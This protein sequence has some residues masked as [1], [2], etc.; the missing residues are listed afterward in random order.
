MCKCFIRG[1][2][3]KIEQRITRN[4]GVQETIAD[5]LR[6]EKELH[7]MT[8]LKL[9]PDKCEFLKTEVIYLGHVISKDG[10]KPDPKK[11]EAVRQFPRPKTSKNIKQFLELAGYLTTDASGIAIGGILSQGEINKDRPIAYASRTL[12]KNE[13]KYDIYEKEALA[14]VYCVKHFRLKMHRTQTCKRMHK[15]TMK[16]K[17]KKKNLRKDIQFRNLKEKR[18]NLLLLT[19]TNNQELHAPARRNFP[20]RRVIVR[21]YDDLWQT[22]VVEMRP[23]SGFNIDVLSKYTWAVY[24]LLKSKGGSE[25]AN[26]IAE[27]VRESRRCPKNLQTD[28]AKE[29]YNVDVQKILKKHD[30]NHYSTLK[31]SVIERFNRTF[32]NDIAIKI[33][34]PAKFKIGDSV[35]VSKY[36]TIF[37]KGYTPNWT[38]EV[39]TIVKVQ[40]TNPVT[41]LYYYKVVKYKKHYQLAL[42]I[43]EGQRQGPTMTLIYHF[44]RNKRFTVVTENLKLETVSIAK[45]D[46][47]NNV[48]WSNIKTALQLVVMDSTIK[49]IICNGL[50]KYPP[51]DFRSTIIGEMHCL[52]TGRHRGVTKTYNRI[53]HKYHWENLKSDIQRYIQQYLQCQL[54]KLVR[55][56][57]K[58]PM[59]ITDTRSFFDKLQDQLTKF[60]MGIPLSDQT[61]TITEAF[62]DRFICVLGAPKAILTNQGRNFISELMKKIAKIFRIRKFRTTAF[63]PQS[64][65]SL[66]RSYH[67][68]GEYL[69][70]YANEQKQ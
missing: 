7:S 15:A 13:I 47:V 11:L 61:S 23:Y 22:D 33:V 58:Q 36:K 49:L 28:M 46:Y 68:L 2:K 27:I 32:K 25:T 51:K 34:D 4:L 62:V 24:L 44:R 59:I 48:L 31:A 6:I 3:S 20:R 42:S 17:I 38:T 21:G 67:A 57:T 63:H 64:N 12:T 14:I 5:A 35:R 29:F 65:G 19:K 53:K 56:N 16:R 45:T 70:Q 1:L 26:A 54:K 18:E 40:R 30:V 39:F 43:S 37:E 60:C 66:E 50:I 8:E 52:S 69:K 10:I 41:Y 55:V 9:Q